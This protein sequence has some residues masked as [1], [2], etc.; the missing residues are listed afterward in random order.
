MAEVP[1]QPD[2]AER[3]KDRTTTAPNPGSSSTTRTR[4][5]DQTTNSRAPRRD[6]TAT[7]PW[8]GRIQPQAQRDT[9]RRAGPPTHE[10]RSPSRT[11]RLGPPD[12]GA[13]A[14]WQPRT[15]DPHDGLTRDARDGALAS[16]QRTDTLGYW[17]RERAGG[18]RRRWCGCRAALLTGRRRPGPCAS[19]GRPAGQVHGA[20]GLRCVGLRGLGGRAR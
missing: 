8:T 9:R 14:A 13:V 11:R 18:W 19:R 10:P 7:T 15:P 2:P 3:P 6:T 5:Q 16:S 20:V 12:A 1:E 17:W 4:H